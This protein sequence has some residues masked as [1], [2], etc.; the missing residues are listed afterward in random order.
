MTKEY[1][2]KDLDFDAWNWVCKAI[3]KNDRHSAFCNA[4]V[5]NGE[6]IATDGR[7][8]HVAKL[9]LKMPEGQYEVLRHSKTR[10][11]VE[12]LENV[13]PY[14]MWRQIWPSDDPDFL[15]ANFDPTEM[16]EQTF[17]YAVRNLSEAT[18]FNFKFFSEALPPTVFRLGQTNG[19]SPA[20]CRSTDG[21]YRSILMP[22]RV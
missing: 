18:A 14:P 15:K 9:K 10:V 19:Q 8:M 16:P 3:S 21:E 20:I 11:E 22:M 1:R 2:T 5:E 6:L 4:L 7:R 17:A 13:T 12:L